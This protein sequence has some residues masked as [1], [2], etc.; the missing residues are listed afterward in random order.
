MEDLEKLQ[1]NED[2]GKYIL[3]EDISQEDAVE[4]SELIER[5]VR[6][7]AKKDEEISLSQWLGSELK[8]ELPERTDKQISDMT[9]EII[10]SVQEFDDNLADL[11]EQSEKGVESSIWL[12][13]KISEVSTGVSVINFG[14]YLNDIDNSL[15]NA[16]AQMMRTV[17]TSAGEISN[18]MNLDGFIAEQNA[19]NTFN[20]QAQLEGSKYV[21]EV[22]VPK[23]GE[24]YGLNSFDTVI[25]DSNTGKIVH[26]Y[27]FKFGK[28]A[29]ST[30]NLLKDGNY[31]NQRFVVPADQVEEVRKAFPGKSVEAYMGGTD[32]VSVKSGTLTK[33]QAKKL[34]L[35]TQQKGVLPKNDWNSFNTKGLAINIGKNA[36]LAGLNAA[37]VTTGFDLMAKKIQGEQIDG[38]KTIETA[39]RTGADSGVKAATAG[40]LKVVSEKG[41]LSVIPQGT[42]ASVITNIACVAIED[43]KIL[44]KVANGDITMAEALDM[45]GRTSVAMVYGIGW[46]ATG[47]AIGAAALSWIPIAGPVIGGIVGATV[48]YVAGSKF[49]STL[50]SGLKKVGNAVKTVASKVWSGVKTVASKIG[51]G[52]SRIGSGLRGLFR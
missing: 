25:K 1:L 45:M 26:Q 17:T 38:E 13:N 31:N 21:A 52:L 4:A 18:C 41:I 47:M 49:G 51:R 48:G 30:I 40:A 44:A 42:P 10:N 23:L 29:K 24:T 7:Y 50:Y 32:V 43:A 16:N 46:G 39:L 19:V 27:Q 15:I 28:D 6:S 36:G 2:N 33:E 14:N 11:N 37:L 8:K 9:N 3:R 5:F 20:M 35:D 12:S 22:K 34:Q